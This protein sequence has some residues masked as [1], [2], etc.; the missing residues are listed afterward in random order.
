MAD[1]ERVNG[2]GQPAR[3]NPETGVLEAVPSE[4]NKDERTEAPATDPRV[5]TDETPAE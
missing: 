4:D 2:L 3:E 5:E 1:N